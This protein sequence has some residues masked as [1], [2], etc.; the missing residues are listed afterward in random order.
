VRLLGSDATQ[1]TDLRCQRELLRRPLAGVA[2][3]ARGRAAS[4]A[5]TDGTSTA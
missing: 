4:N 3:A 2:R 1:L 5:A